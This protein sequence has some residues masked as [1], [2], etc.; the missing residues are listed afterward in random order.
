V[1]H[2]QEGVLC[3]VRKHEGIRGLRIWKMVLGL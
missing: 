1:V 2:L 3:R